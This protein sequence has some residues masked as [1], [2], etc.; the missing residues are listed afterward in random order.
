VAQV[1]GAFAAISEVNEFLMQNNHSLPEV[2]PAVINQEINMDSVS[3][4]M[5]TALNALKLVPING[6]IIAS[7][8]EAFIA[9]SKALVSADLAFFVAHQHVQA[10]QLQVCA[11]VAS[12]VLDRS[13]SLQALSRRCFW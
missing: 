6:S 3:L 7:T 13:V 8:V 4:W 12:S 10:L 2:L 9:D 11:R 1:A 5:E